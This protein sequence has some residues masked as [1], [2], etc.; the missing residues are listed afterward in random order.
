MCKIYSLLI[1][2]LT[3]CSTPTYALNV[4]EQKKSHKV[5]LNQ[6]SSK[7]R[8]IAKIALAKTASEEALDKQKAAAALI[9]IITLLLLDDSDSTPNLD[10]D[11]DTINN[12]QDNCPSIANQ[13]Q[14]DTDNDGQGDACDDDDDNDGLT[15]VEELAQSTNP[16]KADTDGDLVSDSQDDFPT[17]ITKV[18][19]KAKAH[20]LLVQA[21]FGPTQ[22]EL[23]QVEATGISAWINTQLNKSSAYDN[24]NDNHKTHLERVIQMALALEPAE[25]WMENTVFNRSLAS[26]N[27]NK[28]QMAT[29]WENTLGHPTNTAHGS[30]QLRQRIAYALSQIL[31]VSNSAPPL[32][33]RAEGLAFYYDILAK[34]AFGNYRT[35]LGEMARSPTMGMYLSHQGNRKTNLAEATSPDENFARELIQLFSIGLHELN[36][37][38]SPNR[39]TY[40]NT[41]PDTGSN[42]VPTYTQEDVTEMAKVMTGWDLVGNSRYGN[43][44]NRQGDYTTFMEFTA[45]E[46]EDEIAESGDGSVTILGQPFALNSG[47]DGSGLD[48]ALDLLFQHANVAPFVSRHL[49]KHLVTSNPSSDYVARIAT[50]FNNNGSGVKGDLKAVVKAILLDDEA[51]NEANIQVSS[52]GKA[53]EPILALTQFLRAFKVRP[54][55]GWISKDSSTVVNGV[56]WYR[57]PQVHFGHAPLRSPSVFNFY[58]PG[59]IP[60][61]SYFSQNKLVA[62]ELQI[63]TDQI[64]VEMNNRILTMINS[65]EKNRII[66]QKGLSLAAYAA[67]KKFSSESLFLFDFDKE[68]AVYEQALDG[69]TDGDFANM[70][71]TN[72]DTGL[73][74]K[75]GAIDALLEHLNQLLLGGTMTTKYRAAFKHFLMSSSGSRNSNDAKEAWINIKDAVRF[76]VTSNAFMIQK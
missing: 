76:I 26:F 52:F 15:D 38:G 3:I 34:N 57:K 51:R 12:T 60:S 7:A 28:Y 71:L 31:V 49:I 48:S 61:D 6:Q 75:E 70:E 55:D 44:T 13:D 50:V 58:S 45:S 23:A 63:Q 47:A 22:E 67:T 29:W 8:S 56:Y 41:Y 36:L 53:K 1:V 64:L 35:L 10:T 5:T 11:N 68:L 74:Y 19:T 32:D 54:L 37:D 46:H 42:V 18:A 33:R 21:S 62:P 27:V 59:F 14:K 17:D 73:R 69:D 30:D 16:L 24:P 43:S 72:P 39:D 9:P 2:G 20:R 65:Y 4:A 40:P 66:T 25:D